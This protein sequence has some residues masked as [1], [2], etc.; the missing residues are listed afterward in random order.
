MGIFSRRDYC[1]KMSQ[2]PAVIFCIRQNAEFCCTE[3]NTVGL[4]IFV[5][6]LSLSDLDA[7]WVF[8]GDLM[9]LFG[10][11]CDNV[12]KTSPYQTKLRG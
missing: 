6:P 3:H 12:M 5:F 7:S 4:G 2:V 10:L 9:M 11:F 8:F 1:V